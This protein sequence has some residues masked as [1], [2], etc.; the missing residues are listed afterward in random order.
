MNDYANDIMI[1][2]SNFLRFLEIYHK[3]PC[4]PKKDWQMIG[5]YSMSVYA[6]PSKRFCYVNLY[7]T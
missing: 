6:L 2:S 7:L 3:R 1:K 5:R 4:E